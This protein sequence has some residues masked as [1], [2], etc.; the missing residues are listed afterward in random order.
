MV[1]MSTQTPFW[2]WNDNKVGGENVEDIHAL[3][4]AYELVG[5][6]ENKVLPE[7]PYA[8][9]D[10][11]ERFPELVLVG[12]SKIHEMV[13]IKMKNV[14]VVVVVAG[15]TTRTVTRHGRE[16][17]VAGYIILELI[18]VAEESLHLVAA[19]GMWVVAVEV[20]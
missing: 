10:S 18:D 16:E 11:G 8:V 19:L 3:V 6:V 20:G 5:L 13:V 9:P 2:R 14:A 12:P 7:G 1:Q 15:S 17:P 4:V